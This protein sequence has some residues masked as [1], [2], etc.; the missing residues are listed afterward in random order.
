M[1]DEK[2]Q[3]NPSVRSMKYEPQVFLGHCIIAAQLLAKLSK[4]LIG[5][6]CIVG[7]VVCAAQMVQQD[8]ALSLPIHAIAVLNVSCVCVC[9][10]YSKL[11]T[12]SLHTDC[13]NGRSTVAR[14]HTA[15]VGQQQPLLMTVGPTQQ[16]LTQDSLNSLNVSGSIELN[17]QFCHLL[18]QA[19]IL[20][21]GHL[22]VS[23][24]PRAAV[25]QSCKS[26]CVFTVTEIRRGQRRFR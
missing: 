26:V 20:E 6:V 1:L 15:R 23:E 19:D 2:V 22:K 7:G 25:S 3:L 8:C 21:M 17:Q 18:I 12:S 4:S 13:Y 10:K 14:T 5:G 16:I 9:D 11:S 24:N